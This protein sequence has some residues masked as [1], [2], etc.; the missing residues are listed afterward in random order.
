MFECA[1]E[2]TSPDSHHKEELGGKNHKCLIIA[3]SLLVSPVN[4]KERFTHRKKTTPLDRNRV[5][6]LSSSGR[7]SAYE[8][9][10]V[11]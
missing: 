9:L 2:L 10:P 3:I 8:I 1:A 5:N 11:K 6:T 4:V 7:G